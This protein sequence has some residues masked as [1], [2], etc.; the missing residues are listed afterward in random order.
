ME[1]YTQCPNELAYQK[2]LKTLNDY[3]KTHL[4]YTRDAFKSIKV[5]DPTKKLISKKVISNVVEDINNYFQHTNIITIYNNKGFEVNIDSIIHN[6]AFNID[7]DDFKYHF[8]L[9]GQYI[10][11]PLK[12]YIIAKKIVRSITSRLYFD[13]ISDIKNLID[14]PSELYISDGYSATEYGIIKDSTHKLTRVYR[15]SNG[16]ST[17]KINISNLKT[18]VAEYLRV[19]SDCVSLYPIASTIMNCVET[20]QTY[21]DAI[22]DLRTSIEDVLRHFDGVKVVK[23][24]NK[25]YFS[26]RYMNECWG[27]I[28]DKFINHETDKPVEYST[29]L[30]DIKIFGNE[31][32]VSRNRMHRYEPSCGTFPSTVVNEAKR[33]IS[34]KLN[35]S[36]VNKIK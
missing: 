34:K 13:N 26:K 35:R 19:D 7:K 4:E 14:I 22:D 31:F 33:V 11:I 20:I 16:G 21:T 10:S 17:Y 18:I 3:Y 25:Y 15:C 36:K 2:I 12:K 32:L 28:S 24:K 23:H 8:S 5:L 27:R 9:L 6:M 1:D 29:F 30:N